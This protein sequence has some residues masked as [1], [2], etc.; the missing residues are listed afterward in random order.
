M[1]YDTKLSIHIPT[2]Q[3]NTIE[4]MESRNGDGSRMTTTRQRDSGLWALFTFHNGAYISRICPQKLIK[5]G[6]IVYAPATPDIDVSYAFERH[7]CPRRDSTSSSLACCNSRNGRCAPKWREFRNVTGWA[8][9][10]QSEKNKAA[11]DWSTLR[12]TFELLLGTACR[13]HCLTLIGCFYTT[14]Y[15]LVPSLDTLHSNSKVFHMQ[16][17]NGEL[18]GCHRE[19]GGQ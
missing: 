6:Q 17:Q 2:A 10:S 8:R 18:C 5:I 3:N 19:R 15:A 7:L 12:G 9:E 11:C 14:W 4:T 13:D 16:V 1:I